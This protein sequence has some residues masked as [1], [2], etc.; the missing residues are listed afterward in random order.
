MKNLD[1]KGAIAFKTIG[2]NDLVDFFWCLILSE[3]D[4]LVG[5][6]FIRRVGEFLAVVENDRVINYLMAAIV[7]NFK[8]VDKSLNIIINSIN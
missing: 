5:D 1:G 2:F 7:S 3:D 8:R 6:H 4:G